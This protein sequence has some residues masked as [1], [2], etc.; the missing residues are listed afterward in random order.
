MT[1][2]IIY[3]RCKEYTLILIYVRV[4]T[5]H[6]LY[7]IIGFRE[8]SG[9]YSIVKTSMIPLKTSKRLLGLICKKQQGLC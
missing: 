5:V 2:R 6:I 1:K 9:I 8:V 7:N 4:R 3:I